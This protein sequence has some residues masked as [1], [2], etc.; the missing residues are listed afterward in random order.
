MKNKIILG[1]IATI[2]LLIPIASADVN[3]TQS[4]YSDG[5]IESHNYFDSLGDTDFYVNGVEV[6]AYDT[7]RVLQVEEYI[8][9]NQNYWS[10]DTSGIS[11]HSLERFFS[12]VSKIVTGEYTWYDSD[13]EEFNVAGFLYNAFI[14]RF[15]FM[16]YFTNLEFRVST[17]EAYLGRNDMTGFC[18]SAV[19]NAKEYGY[20][21]INCGGHKYILTDDEAITIEEVK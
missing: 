9:N 6:S 5:D 4:I 19:N 18:I 21:S 7:P 16:E 15:E 3:I 13:D 10:V 17:I 12:R 8:S 20:K 11:K 14:S 2:F 1:L